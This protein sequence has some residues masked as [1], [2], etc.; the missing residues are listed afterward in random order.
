[1]LIVVINNNNNNNTNPLVFIVTL[2]Y[3]ISFLLLLNS[4]MVPLAVTENA[5]N[6]RVHEHTQFLEGYRKNRDQLKTQQ[7][8]SCSS[9]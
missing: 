6:S 7:K 2:H 8:H 5:I 9:N 4:N 3:Q 1:M